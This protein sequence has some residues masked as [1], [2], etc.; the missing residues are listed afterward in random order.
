MFDG[1]VTVPK[2]GDVASD[3]D[4]RLHISVIVDISRGDGG[5]KLEFLCSAWPDH[6]EIQ[7]VYL[8][9]HRRCWVGLLWD[10]ISESMTLSSFLNNRIGLELQRRQ[11]PMF[12]LLGR[13]MCLTQ[14]P[15]DTLPFICSFCIFSSNPLLFA[16]SPDILS[17]NSPSTTF[18][19]PT[20]GT[21]LRFGFQ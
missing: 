2:L 4:L 21:Q 10:L 18:E 6:L 14:F 19:V 15:V 20:R 13:T 11:S 7:K 1:Y 5:E 3:E 12:Q 17:R 8:L 9:G 16:S